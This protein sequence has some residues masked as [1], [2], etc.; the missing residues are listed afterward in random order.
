MAKKVDYDLIY[1]KLERNGFKCTGIYEISCS[2][3]ILNKRNHHRC[4]NMDKSGDCRKGN[5]QSNLKNLYSEKIIQ[6][7]LKAILE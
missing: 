3:N 4:L 7:K 1:K 2:G 5:V 6:V